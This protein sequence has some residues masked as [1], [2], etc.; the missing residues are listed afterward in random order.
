MG[1]GSLEKKFFYLVLWKC[2]NEM[3]IFFPLGRI[4]KSDKWCILIAHL[5]SIERVLGSV[6]NND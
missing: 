2:G 6:R 1:Y 5:R 4:F 3:N